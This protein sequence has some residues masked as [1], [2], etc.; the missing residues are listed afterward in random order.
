M[1]TFNMRFWRLFPF[2]LVAS[3]WTIP[4]YSLPIG[5]GH[6]QGRLSYK[7]VGNEKV[8]VYFD[9][10]APGEARMV[11]ESMSAGQP[12]LES[13]LGARRDRR[14]PIVM[15][16]VASGASFANFVTDAIELQTLGQGTRDL[17]WHELTHML[18]YGHL[19]NIL[20]HTGAIIHLIWMPTWFLE[21]LAEAMSVSEGSDMQAGYERFHAL[22]GRWPTYERLHSLYNVGNVA[23]QGYNSSGAW[24]SYILRQHGG[25]KLPDL[26][27]NFYDNSMPWWWPW[28]AVPFGPFLPMDDAIQQ[29]TQQKSPELYETYKQAAQAY[30]RASAKGPFLFAKA[31]ARRYFNLFQAFDGDGQRVWYSALDDDKIVRKEVIF[32]AT[33][34]WAVDAKAIDTA[35][36]DAEFTS[37]VRDD[38]W[39]VYA[40]EADRDPGIDTGFELQATH[41]Q[42]RREQTVHVSSGQLV[43]LHRGRTHL[44]W[45]ERR[46][47]QF[48]VCRLP[49]AQWAKKDASTASNP[50]CG[51]NWSQPKLV[52]TLG[53]RRGKSADDSDRVEEIWLSEQ[54]QTLKGDRY[55]IIA[56]DPD[57]AGRTRTLSLSHGGTPHSVAFAGEQIWL[58]TGERQRRTLRRIDAHGKCQEVRHLEDTPYAISGL[59]DGTLVAGLL[60]GLDS[61]ML[62]FKPSELTTEPCYQAPM[63]SSP[64]LE[65]Q[66]AGKP[67]SLSE[68][69]K[70]SSIWDEGRKTAENGE[71]AARTAPDLGRTTQESIQERPAGWRPRP[72][73]GVPWIA[74]DALGYNFGVLSV[75]LMDNMQNETLRLTSLWGVESR[76]P[77]TQL[78]LTSTRFLPT[79]DLDLYRTQAWNGVY[80]NSLGG[81][82]SAYS[83]E[84]GATLSAS[85]YLRS[86]RLGIHGSMKTAKL[87]PYIGPRIDEGQLSELT[88]G[89]SRSFRLGSW[90]WSHGLSGVAAPEGMNEEFDYNKIGY[91]TKLTRY[92]NWRSA[93]LSLGLSGSR[94]RGPK[95]RLLQEVYRPLKTFIPGSG[96]GLNNV[97][98]PIY[99]VGGLFT[100]HF[101]DTQARSSVDFTFPLVRNLDTLIRIVYLQSIEFSAFFNYGA[102]WRGDQ[103]PGPSD[104]IAAHGYNLD[105]LMDI[106]GVNFNFG[107]G[108]GQVL[109]D[110]FETYA[111][112]GFDA[113]L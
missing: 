32:D 35:P 78:T 101:G 93:R 81:L 63:H 3:L 69:V 60:S 49:W 41:R 79:L 91:S 97:N 86:W 26:L 9:E 103:L 34:G 23:V 12:I 6:N 25:E 58:L 90:I 106:K 14:L 40:V 64:L 4:S 89:L 46:Q 43:R 45:L 77:S 108:S 73:F 28:A 95:R 55:R 20:G 54:T 105:L 18:M 31:G 66:R 75:P 48:L 113:I 36:E 10:R 16:A 1:H 37:F 50:D 27:R 30:W 8:I 109:G 71:A 2:G 61:Y 87:E 82:S 111:S 22:T 11:L 38:Q 96:G 42:T 112:F 7:E 44:I 80:T 13:W 83:D 110:Q 70:L 47:E 74:A 52:N 56:L 19:E 39:E 15:T 62:R 67:I 17:A 5:F 92:L 107:L 53:V 21:G 98:F 102:A 33:S 29:A 94:T 51:Q 84:I 85:Y 76:Y 100:G 72:L 99:G 65:A 59:S 24:V 68:A 88:L 57:D 104:M